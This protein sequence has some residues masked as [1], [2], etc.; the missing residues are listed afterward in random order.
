MAPI[1]A[2]SFGPLSIG[3]NNHPRYADA[4]ERSGSHLDLGPIGGLGELF[5]TLTV[6]LSYYKGHR[7]AS[8]LS[9][10]MIPEGRSQATI[11]EL[12]AAS[13][14]VRDVVKQ[15]KATWP[16]SIGLGALGLEAAAGFAAAVIALSAS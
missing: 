12:D 1:P 11:P 8:E 3:L 4:H 13:V 9:G 10:I 15:L 14:A 16:Q 5:G 7:I 6:A 2:R